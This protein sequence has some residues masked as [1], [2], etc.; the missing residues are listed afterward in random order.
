MRTAIAVVAAGIVGALVGSVVTSHA[1]QRP[2]PHQQA[3]LAGLSV[4]ASSANRPGSPPS[5]A[6]LS[7]TDRATARANGLTVPATGPVFAN[8]PVQGVSALIP[9]SHGAWWALADNGYGARNTSAD[10]QLA[11]YK[12]NLNFGRASGPTV[13]D[14]VILSDPGRKVP[15]QTVCDPTHGSP[16]PPLSFNVLPG[17]PPPACGTDPSARLLTGFDFDPESVQIAR[18]G[19]FWIGDEFGP[20]LLHADTRGRLLEAPISYPGVKSP[21]NP[22]LNV[23]AGEAPNLAGSRGFEDLAVSPD[24]RHLYAMTEGAIGA[25]DPQ[26]LRI[27]TFDI[28]HRRFTGEVRKLRLEFPGAKVDLSTLLLANGARAYPNAVAP[29]GTGG[30]SAADL[31]A[32]DDHRFLVVERDSNG[33]A[34]PAPRMKKVFILDTKG[35]HRRSGYVDKQPLADL[36]AV[37]DPKKLGGDGDFFRFP[38]NTIESVHVVNDHTIVVANDNNYP[39]SNGRSRSKTNERTGPLAPDDNEFIL[40]DLSASLHPDPRLLPHF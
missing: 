23:L 5:G 35:A 8:Q 34:I 3:Q 20:F 38:F 19:T 26:D 40:I 11:M 12:M 25:D 36:M 14:T 21:Q 9:A 27:A 28:A 4:L 16:L 13:L 7:A 37:P 29:T 30:E 10:W 24:R 18:D 6:F 15:W 31:T 32:L 39:F 22:T 1:D 2:A 33:D 17:S